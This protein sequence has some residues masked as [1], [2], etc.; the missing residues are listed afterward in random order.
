[1]SSS[2]DDSG[3]V[4]AEMIANVDRMVGLVC[5]FIGSQIVRTIAQLS[6]PD[7]LAR[8]PATAGEVAKAVKAD[9]GAMTRLLRAAVPLGLVRYGKDTGR[10]HST[11]LL[12][13]LQSDSKVSL[14]GW[15]IIMGTKVGPAPAPP[16]PPMTSDHRRVLSDRLRLIFCHP[17]PSLWLRL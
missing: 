9:E 12:S 17:S 15:S 10:F 3:E 11:Q 8:G 7:V 14:R 13:V 5:G 2:A 16:P 6:I 4:G 1:M